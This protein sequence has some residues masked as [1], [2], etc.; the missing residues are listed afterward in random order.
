MAKDSI[1][2]LGI[3]IVIHVFDTENNLDTVKKIVSD[4]RV[5]SSNILF[6]PIFSKNFN[7]TKNF[8]RKD[9]NKILINPLSKNYN[10]LKETSNIYFLT[11]Y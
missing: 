8:F 2:K 10:F 5:K 1:E 4:E 3:P 9:S 11:P 6:G 7:L